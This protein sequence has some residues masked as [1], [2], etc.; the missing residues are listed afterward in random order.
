MASIYLD[1]HVVI[2]LYEGNLKLLS[3]KAAYK[4][5]QADLLISPMVKL[6]L[7]YLYEVGRKNHDASTVLNGL[8]NIIDLSVD[9]RKYR[10]IV[11]HSL[12]L[13]WTR[14]PFDRLIAAQAEVMKT[15]LLTKD[16]RLLEHCKQAVW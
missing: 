2:W 4:I 6:E 12:G 1:T 11:D 3:Q 14:D 5:E 13:D 16:T 9:T 15:L 10:K 8:Q 7:Q